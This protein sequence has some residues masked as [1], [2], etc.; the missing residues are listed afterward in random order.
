MTGVQT[1]A[2]PIS[3]PDDLRFDSKGNQ[4]EPEDFERVGFL[5][6]DQLGEALSM[7]PEWIERTKE[8]GLDY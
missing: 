6:D 2:L 3:I 5:S 4:P 1:C 7:L 8:L